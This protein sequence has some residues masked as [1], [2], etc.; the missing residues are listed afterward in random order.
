MDQVTTR[1]TELARLF[2]SLGSI[3]FGGPAAHNRMFDDEVVRRRGQ[4]KD[5]ANKK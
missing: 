4:Q 1:L 5:I 2:L 3:A